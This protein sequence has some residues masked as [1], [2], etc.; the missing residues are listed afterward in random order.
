[1]DDARPM[2]QNH[3]YGTHRKH[4]QEERLWSLESLITENHK[5]G[6]HP[7]D[8]GA[9]EDRRDVPAVSVEGQEDASGK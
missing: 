9:V 8:T 7:S 2:E 5:R 1:M 6:S 4:E 3:A